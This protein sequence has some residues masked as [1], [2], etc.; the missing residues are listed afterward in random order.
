M[1]IHDLKCNMCNHQLDDYV[2][3]L[4]DL[5]K[6]IGCKNPDNKK[7]AGIYE[8]Q[9]KDCPNLTYAACP[10]RKNLYNNSVKITTE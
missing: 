5:G 7:C 4:E 6:P 9:W 10:S 2:I 3:K 1:A 8:I